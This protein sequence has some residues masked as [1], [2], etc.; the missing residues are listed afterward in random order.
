MNKLTI[1]ITITD[2]EIL[3]KIADE[4]DED[5]IQDFFYYPETWLDGADVEVDR[6]KLTKD[7]REALREV[8]TSQLGRCRP[9][10]RCFREVVKE[11]LATRL[12]GR[13]N[14]FADS[15]LMAEN[16]PFHIEVEMA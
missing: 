12:A 2:P 3:K 1:T 15:D 6:N 13:K 4:S 14:R 9:P 11:T 8:V 5:I 7:D 16:D 10:K